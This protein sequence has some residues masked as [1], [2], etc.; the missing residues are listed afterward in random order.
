MVT[1]ITDMMGRGHHRTNT[2]IPSF[3]P[4]SSLGIVVLVVVVLKVRNRDAPSDT[5]SIM[6]RT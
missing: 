5:P 1:P 4:S 2:S 3:T 6:L